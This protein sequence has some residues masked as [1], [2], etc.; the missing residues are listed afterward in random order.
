[1]KDGSTHLAHKAEHAVDMESG[2]VVAVTLQAADQGDTTTIHETLAEAGEAVAEL[3]E[4]EAEKTPEAKP[5]VHVNG[6]TEIVADKGYHSG[7]NGGGIGAGGGAELHPGTEAGRRKWEGKAEEQQAV[8]A[9]RRRV[10]R[11]S[12]QATLE[13][14]R[15]TDRTI[16]CALLRNRRDETNASERAREHSEAAVDS[17]LRVQLEPNLPADSGC[18]N[19]AGAEKPAGRACFGLYMVADCANGAGATGSKLSARLR[20]SNPIEPSR[21]ATPHLELPLPKFRGFHHGLLGA[22]CWS[23]RR[24]EDFPRRVFRKSRSAPTGCSMTLHSHG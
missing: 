17:R 24:R 6:I 14:A 23:C 12:R 2:A 11:P 22:I 10:A 5:Q 16:L 19:A 1:M 15:G 7:Q 13:E 4:R 21:L 9:N 8:Y 3:I 20:M 18:R